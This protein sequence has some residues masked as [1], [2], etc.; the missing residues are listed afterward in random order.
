VR[1]NDAAPWPVS[2]D[3][4]GTYLSRIDNNAYGNDPGN[5]QTATGSVHIAEQPL[6]PSGFTI[7]PNPV[8]SA[9]TIA[10]GTEGTSELRVFDV[11]GKLVH[12]D[13]FAGPVFY[14]T[15]IGLK[16]GFYTV[17]IQ[18]ESGIQSRRIVVN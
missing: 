14:W 16:P 13:S 12:T 6:L 4:G 17:S 9:T 3:G 18:N 2:A 11:S 15:N 5:W 7:N 1:Y 8:Y 10:V